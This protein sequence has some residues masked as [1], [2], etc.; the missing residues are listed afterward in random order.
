[1]LAI[2]LTASAIGRRVFISPATVKTHRYR[3]YEKIGVRNHDELVDVLGLIQDGETGGSSVA[4]F[5]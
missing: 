4:F 3:I 5:L 2:G 1:M